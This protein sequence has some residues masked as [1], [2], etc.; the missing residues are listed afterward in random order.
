VGSLALLRVN[1]EHLGISRLTAGGRTFLFRHYLSQA[2]NPIVWNVIYDALTGQ[3]VNSTLSVAQQ[4]LI[5]VLLAQQPVPVT[6]TVFFSQPAA[7]A[8][9][10]LTKQVSTD[11]G[12]GFVIDDLL[13]ELQF[14]FTPTSGNLRELNV[15]FADNLTPM[16]ALSQPDIN[17]RQD[18][19]G[20]FSRAFPAFTLVT[21]Q[22]PGTFGQFVFD[23]WLVNGQPQTTQVPAVAVFLTGNTRVEARYR[24]A[25]SAVALA[26]AAA[27]AGEI[28]FTITTEAGAHYTIEQ[29]PQLTNPVWTPVETRT[30]DGSRILVIRPIGAAAAFFRVR[31]DP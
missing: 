6:N 14:D 21:L 26:P 17:G 7:H 28:G 9:L 19:L 15:Q 27:P 29:T 13:F 22:A 2:V 23:R 30:G 8:D 5:S 31:V 20:D 18:G 16:I 12:T 24:G 3:T 1:Y 4:S 25:I 11:N 10:L